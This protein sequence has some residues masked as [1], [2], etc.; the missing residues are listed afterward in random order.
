VKVVS[1]TGSPD[2]NPTP[3]PLNP[4]PNHTDDTAAI[5]NTTDSHDQAAA[6]PH[7]VAGITPTTVPSVVTRQVDWNDVL[8]R[9]AV[10]MNNVPPDHTMTPM[11]GD[12]PAAHP[13]VGG[14]TGHPLIDGP[15]ANSQDPLHMDVAA[16]EPGVSPGVGPGIGAVTMD[17]PTAIVPPITPAT[18]PSTTVVSGV[19]SHRVASGETLSI[20]SKAV[21]GSAKYWDKILAANP[22]INP[23]NL[24]VGSTLVIP[25]L[26][27][28][29]AVSSASTGSDHGADLPGP[30]EAAGTTGTV[31]P[32]TTYVVVSGDSLEKISIKLY[33][34]PQMKDSLYET[35]KG[36]F[37]DDEDVLKVGMLLKLTKAPTVG[38]TANATSS[39]ASR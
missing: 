34:K 14:V 22:N 11:P 28:A 25:D 23:K 31:D 35:N 38:A 15:L 8:Q 13:P 29:T 17:H 26:K 7:A 20:I 5:N 3:T 21:Y 27:A 19:R 18:Q 24:K 6:D 1:G 37:G 32:T 39:T 12:V 36:V 4:A 30:S 16:P 33:G 2:A 9:G 10:A